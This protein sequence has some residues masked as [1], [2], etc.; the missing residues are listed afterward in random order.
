MIRK[1]QA[2]L[3]R[4]NIILD[5]ILVILSYM[6]ATWLR[7]DIFD[8]DSGNMA[9][10]STT[11][12]VDGGHTVDEDKSV[13]IT[14]EVA[15]SNLIP[16]ISYRLEG[17]LIRKSDGLDFMNDGVA[18]TAV[19]EFVPGEK[20]GSIVINFPEFDSDDLQDEELVAFEK[21]YVLTG[22]EPLQKVPV[23]IHEDINEGLLEARTYIFLVLFHELR[24][25]S[26]LVTDKIK[27]RSL[28]PAET[29][30]ETGYMR[31]GEMELFRISTLGET[32]DHGT[33]GI[34]EAKHLRTFIERFPD[35]IVNSLP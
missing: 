14:D 29:V 9:G 3:N 30:I 33:A 13:T 31:L 25:F 21:L 8:G 19:V 10:I 34:T 23:A 22:D 28:Y 5:M 16:G 6:L 12:T 20:D 4:V 18:V 24:I 11:A 1:N 26:H 2:F 15:Y 35:R 27:E 32:I 7:L 17:R